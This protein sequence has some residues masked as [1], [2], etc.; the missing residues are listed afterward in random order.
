M[1]FKD[2]DLLAKKILVGLVVTAVPALILIGGLW[3]TQ[4]VLSGTP[5]HS[6]KVHAKERP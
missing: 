5:E 4:H 1:N 6:K 3:A 2:F